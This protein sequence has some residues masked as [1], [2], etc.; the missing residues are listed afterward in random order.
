M[1]KQGWTA[2]SKLQ[3]SAN[4]PTPTQQLQQA[5]ESLVKGTKRKSKAA[6]KASEQNGSVFDNTYGVYKD[7]DDIEKQLVS[8]L[9]ETSLK[10][11]R[12]NM[13]LILDDVIGDIKAF[14]NN[15]M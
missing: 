6:A 7:A 13:L 14:E 12:Y 1:M 9:S 2:L 5:S 4:Q 11:T 10:K 3:A 15:P 8:K